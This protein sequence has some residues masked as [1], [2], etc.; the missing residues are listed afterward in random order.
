MGAEQARAMLYRRGAEVAGPRDSDN[1]IGTE[2]M[3]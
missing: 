1:N 2:P 3:C